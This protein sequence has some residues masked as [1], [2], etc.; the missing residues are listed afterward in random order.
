MTA[1]KK[2]VFLIDRGL[3]PSKG[4]FICINIHLTCLRILTYFA[5]ASYTLD[6]KPS[7][8]WG[9][10]FYESR[11]RN[12][13][14]L[15]KQNPFYEYSINKF[16]E[17]EKELYENLH[18][19]FD[20]LKSRKNVSPNTFP[21]DC[22]R[23]ALQEIISDYQWD[24]PE[25]FSPAKLKDRTFGSKTNYIIVFSYSANI[26]NENSFENIDLEKRFIDMLLP[27]TLKSKMGNFG[28]T[29]CWVDIGSEWNAKV[30]TSSDLVV[31]RKQMSFCFIR[32]I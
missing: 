1:S 20:V 5:H 28:I 19:E 26:I 29:L 8:F 32:N 21:G 9:F 24:R 6:I 18:N 14:H 23:D 25:L 27:D 13:T 2:V 15:Y 12:C 3:E 16:Q 4:N 30:W 22:F 11:K 10:K 17:F 31:V 7:V